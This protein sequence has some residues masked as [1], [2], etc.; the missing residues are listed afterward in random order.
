MIAE[1][2]AKGAEDKQPGEQLDNPAPGEEPGHQGEK[3]Q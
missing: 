3:C 1:I 2:D